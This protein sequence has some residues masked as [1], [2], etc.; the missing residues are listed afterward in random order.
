M[1]AI[2]VSQMNKSLSRRDGTDGVS[3]EQW[4]HFLLDIDSGLDWIVRT[5]AF[6]LG[7]RFC[8]GEQ[9]FSWT[10]SHNPRKWGAVSVLDDDVWRGKPDRADIG[11]FP[12]SLLRILKGKPSQC[13]GDVAEALAVQMLVPMEL[14][15]HTPP[16]LVD[17]TIEENAMLALDESIESV[18]TDE[19]LARPQSWI[20]TDDFV[21]FRVFLRPD[22]APQNSAM[23]YETRLVDHL[24]LRRYARWKRVTDGDALECD[25]WGW[26][27]IKMTV[28]KSVNALALAKRYEQIG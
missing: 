15:E 10:E 26:S 3:A 2:S 18:G 9:G 5:R 28:R 19:T 14:R 20:G 6:R 16:R 13:A 1:V 25:E 17:Y 27:P 7:V 4:R 23:K 22:G 21:E 24:L 12:R 11:N 8:I